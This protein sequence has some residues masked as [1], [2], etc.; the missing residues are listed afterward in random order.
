M[1]HLQSP[2]M[3]L[4]QEFWTPFYSLCWLHDC[5]HV[6]ETTK[7]GALR[8]FPL[9]SSFCFSLFL[10]G[11]SPSL[12][13]FPPSPS[14]QCAFHFSPLLLCVFI[15]P[16]S[17]TPLSRCVL[18]L[19][20][21]FSFPLTLLS[22]FCRFFSVSHSVSPLRPP[23]PHISLSSSLSQRCP[24]SWPCLYYLPHCL[25]LR[26]LF[27]SPQS[28]VPF[29]FCSI[30]PPFCLLLFSLSLFLHVLSILLFTSLPPDILPQ[31]LW[32]DIFLTLENKRMVL[33]LNHC[34]FTNSPRPLWTL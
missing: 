24:P 8:S 4:Y 9:F 26:S 10:R 33:S 1:G 3:Q 15:T 6:Y 12:S 22:L 31:T 17:P 25:T 21:S 32:K 27:H 34:L 29:L 2:L 19:P 23:L 18:P 13:L 7:Q 14:F 16:L 20:R 5:G 11:P 28:S 30:T